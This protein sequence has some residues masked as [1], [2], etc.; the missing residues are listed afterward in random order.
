MSGPTLRAPN[1]VELAD[2]LA[3]LAQ[4]AR[5]EGQA[6]AG[7]AVANSA[8]LGLSQALADLV[9]L[10]ETRQRSRLEITTTSN[11]DGSEMK[12][13]FRWVAPAKAPADHFREF[14]K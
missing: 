9:E 11:R 7:A 8:L 14:K 1:F 12:S 13:T 4:A 5:R 6:G 3:A 2:G 10:I